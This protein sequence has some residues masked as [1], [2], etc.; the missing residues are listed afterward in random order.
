LTEITDSP[1]WPR[2]PYVQPFAGNGMFSLHTAYENHPFARLHA[3]QTCRVIAT[4]DHFRL[5]RLG[6]IVITGHVHLEIVQDMTGDVTGYIES[7]QAQTITY[8]TNRCRGIADRFG[9]TGNKS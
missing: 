9:I 5:S 8:A 4:P 1:F 7:N 6:E 2:V 3:G